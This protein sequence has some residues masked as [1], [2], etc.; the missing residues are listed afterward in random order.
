[1]LNDYRV[2]V[3]A[4]K[5]KLLRVGAAVP[6]WRG[7]LKPRMVVTGQRSN[8]QTHESNQRLA[9]MKNLRKEGTKAFNINVSKSKRSAKEEV[10][11][12]LGG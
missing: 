2:L 12:V 4:T 10:E 11:R 5:R 1:M 6:G 9:A 3:V 8:Q 7:R